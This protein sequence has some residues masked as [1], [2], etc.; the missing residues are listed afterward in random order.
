M[1]VCF[2]VNPADNVATALANLDRETVRVLG[3]GEPYC[4]FVGEAIGLGH[5]IATRP[6]V[7]GSEVIKYGVAIGLALSDVAPGDWVH[8]H[9][10]RSRVDERTAAFD[11]HTGAAT[12]TNYA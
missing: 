6:I 5:K 8:L 12:D 2:Q 3:T 7:A 4:L 10:C 1:K 11:P 9:N